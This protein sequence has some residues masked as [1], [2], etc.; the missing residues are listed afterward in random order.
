MEK[1]EMHK[2]V[3]RIKKVSFNRKYEH[4]KLIVR[5]TNTL[6]NKN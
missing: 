6:N 1:T 2:G 5:L 4:Y 3:K